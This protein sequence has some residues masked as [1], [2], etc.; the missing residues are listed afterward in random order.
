MIARSGA[1][2][3]LRLASLAELAGLVRAWGEQGHE[4]IARIA[5]SLLEG[6]HKKQVRT[7][8]GGGNLYDFADFEANMSRDFPHTKVLHWHKQT[9]EWTCQTG[10]GFEGL[11][12]GKVL[13]S[14]SF[15]CASAAL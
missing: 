14:E 11:Q 3:A 9:P 5:E 12:C 2:W 8:L 13:S 7:L 10:K 4:R 1:G 15:L 6:R